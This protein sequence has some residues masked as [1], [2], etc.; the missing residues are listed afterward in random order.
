MAVVAFADDSGGYRIYSSPEEPAA[1][2]AEVARVLMK[3]DRQKR[4]ANHSSVKCVRIRCAQPLT[5]SASALSVTWEVV[6]QLAQSGI[7][8]RG[9]EGE[10]IGG[11]LERKLKLLTG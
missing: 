11:A 1:S 7:D 9:S 8:A 6:P 2:F 3:N 4:I 10:W 5:V